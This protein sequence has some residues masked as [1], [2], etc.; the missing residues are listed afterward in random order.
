MTIELEG[1]MGWTCERTQLRVVIRKAAVIEN[2]PSMNRYPSKKINSL[3]SR[4]KAQ[5]TGNE[6]CHILPT[7]RVELASPE[8]CSL[9]LCTCFP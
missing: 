3:C 5:R 1:E 2:T 9:S 7:A 6:N 8:R 4:P